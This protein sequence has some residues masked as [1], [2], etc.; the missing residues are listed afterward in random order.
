MS[1]SIQKYTKITQQISLLVIYQL[2]I[3]CKFSD[4]QRFCKLQ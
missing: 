4:D 1:K 3:I 2:K